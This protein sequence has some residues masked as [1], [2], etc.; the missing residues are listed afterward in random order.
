MFELFETAKRLPPLACTSPT[1][2]AFTA[3]A[4]D[5]AFGYVMSLQCSQA[6]DGLPRFNRSFFNRNE[7]QK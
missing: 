7:E 6:L 1:Y 2:L 5:G 3:A 4:R